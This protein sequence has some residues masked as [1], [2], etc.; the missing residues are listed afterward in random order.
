[1]SALLEMTFQM[2]NVYGK[3]HS[4]AL[5]DN[6]AETKEHLYKENI[7]SGISVFLGCCLVKVSHPA[8]LD[9][10]NLSIMQFQHTITHVSGREGGGRKEEGL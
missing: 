5:G 6:R 10:T 7:R 8:S 3:T 4:F 2:I 9:D 1:M